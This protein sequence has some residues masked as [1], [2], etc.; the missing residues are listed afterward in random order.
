MLETI[1]FNPFTINYPAGQYFVNREDQL[2]R[3]IELFGSLENRFHN[4]LCVIGKQGEGKT[5]FLDKIVQ[6]SR[7]RRALAFRCNLD[8][9]ESAEK[10]ID[11]VM[12]TLLRE[13]DPKIEDDWNRGKNSTFSTPKLKQINPEALAF[14]LCRIYDNFIKE[15]KKLC[16]VCIDEGERIHPVALL[17]FKNAFQLKSMN[18]M[19]VLSLLNE[20]I[21]DNLQRGSD[22]LLKLSTLSGDPGVSRFFPYSISLGSFETTDAKECI[23]KRL[24]NSKIEFIP[25]AIETVIEAT[26]A[27][28]GKM[29]SLS[30]EVYELAKERSQ[31]KVDKCLVNTAFCKLNSKLIDKMTEY[32]ESLSRFSKT[33]YYELTK[34]D[35]G[36]DSE[37]IMKR[38]HPLY[39]REYILSLSKQASIELDKLCESEFFK[40][41]ICQK[42]DE[43]RYIIPKSEYSYSLRFV[44][45]NYDRKKT[46]W[47]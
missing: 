23:T 35:K 42:D 13:C 34:C 32:I 11:K 33:V 31:I 8:E 16:V 27:N 1:D 14:D 43:N 9:E 10:T 15:K 37:K 47:D 25:E 4:N 45:E 20:T 3:F 36:V 40:E 5:S 19:L 18:Y 6:E 17:A 39:E 28:P 41:T 26:R 44:L 38:I 12:R 7:S 24:E 2:Y 30:H 21:E 22:L 29:I 46:S